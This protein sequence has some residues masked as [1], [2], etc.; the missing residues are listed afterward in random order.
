MRFELRIEIDSAVHGPKNNISKL[1]VR[2]NFPRNP[3]RT[4]PKTVLPALKFLVRVNIMNLSYPICHAY[5]R[6]KMCLCV[7][8][9]WALFR[10]IIIIKSLFLLL[11]DLKLMQRSFFNCKT[12]E[13]LILPPSLIFID[14]SLPGDVTRCIWTTPCWLH[15]FRRK[16]SFRWDINLY[17][18][19]SRDWRLILSLRSRCQKD[20]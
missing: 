4:R 19:T 7:L 9:S 13:N 20:I 17:P 11:E 15:Q 18:K 8:P 16:K 14:F 6:K 1:F 10:L 3:K 2:T 12:D 5:A